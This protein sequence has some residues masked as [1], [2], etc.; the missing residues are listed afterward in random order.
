MRI[1][2]FTNG[3]PFGKA[4]LWKTYELEAFLTEAQSIS[5]IPFSDRSGTDIRI[6]VPEKVNVFQP[7]IS[8]KNVPSIRKRLA[9]ILSSRVGGTF[10]RECIRHKA[11]T[12]KQRLISCIVDSYELVLALRNPSLNLLLRESDTRT[13]WYFF[14]GR[15][16]ALLI[17]YLKKKYGL[18]IAC[19]FHGYD[20]YLERNGGYIPYQQSIIEA[21][22]LLLPCSNHGLRYLKARF[23]H[24]EKK[25]AVARLGT[26]DNGVSSS[27]HG[28]VFSIVSCSSCVPVKRLPLIVEALRALPFNVK[29]THIGDGP[30]LTSLKEMSSTL[31][32]D[33]VDIVFTGFLPNEDVPQYY[34]DNGFDVFLNVSESEG[35]PVSVMEA[36]SVGLPIIATDVGGTS[37]IVD[38]SVG[39]LLPANPSS[40]LVASSISEFQSFPYSRIRDLSTN[41]RQRFL[42]M[43]DADTNARLLLNLFKTRFP[44]LT[45]S[46]GS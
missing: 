19:R 38:D 35:V 14:W 6:D 20:L 3:Y 23:P 37:E 24:I 13:L 29:W 4:V 39:I 27:E 18:N 45:T 11:I 42:T 9:I 26:R 41:A 7:L 46:N 40:A 25:L 33:K 17:P 8:V 28:A 44:A 31:D 22:D 16:A 34:I 10:I 36:L 21:A 30:L 15:D 12:S 32:P 43:C 2:Y 5:V 1:F